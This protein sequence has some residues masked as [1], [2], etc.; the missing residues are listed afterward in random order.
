MERSA[1]GGPLHVQSAP[2]SP[3]DAL[4]MSFLK[5][6]LAHVRAHCKCSWLTRVHVSNPRGSIKFCGRNWIAHAHGRA[7][8]CTARAVAR[9]LLRIIPRV[10]PPS[11]FES[12][13]F[14]CLSLARWLPLLIHQSN[15]SRLQ[16][17]CN[18][19]MLHA[20]CSRAWL[21]RLIC[22]HVASMLT[23]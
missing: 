18:E 5:R 9:W 12:L 22:N 19:W 8:A 10:I 21:W 3:S 6:R 14:I 7:R 13:F 16:S 2:L 11:S 1:Q 20:E 23:Q 15:Q 4:P 17:S